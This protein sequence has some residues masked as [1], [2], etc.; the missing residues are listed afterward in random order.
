[1]FDTQNYLLSWEEYETGDTGLCLLEGTEE[2]ETYLRKKFKERSIGIF[3]DL[4]SEGIWFG[5]YYE[6]SINKTNWAD[7]TKLKVRK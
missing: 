5:E 1:M 2:V 7:K 4:V 6:V 3:E